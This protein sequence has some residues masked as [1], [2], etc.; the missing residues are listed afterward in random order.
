[1]GPPTFAPLNAPHSKLHQWH[2]SL[3]FW[4]RTWAQVEA[5][6]NSRKEWKKERKSL[7]AVRGGASPASY[8]FHSFLE[9]FFWERGF[10]G[11][12]QQAAPAAPADAWR[13][14]SL[15][16]GTRAAVPAA[17]AGFA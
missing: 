13:S 2:R 15:R 6:N 3:K 16:R 17:L 8:L 9:G 5:G 1:L 12:R 11:K 14:L 10:S 7:R 4:K